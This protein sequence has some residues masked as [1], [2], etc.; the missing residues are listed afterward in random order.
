MSPPV[1]D[2]PRKQDRFTLTTDALD[3]GLEAEL[4][5]SKNTITEF[6][7]RTLTPVREITQQQRKNVL[8]SYG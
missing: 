4:S 3:I 5:A 8:Q 1:L 2:Y 7:S 6:A